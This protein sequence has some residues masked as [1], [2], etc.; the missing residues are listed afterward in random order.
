MCTVGAWGLTGCKTRLNPHAKKGVCPEGFSFILL[1][2]ALIF[3][4]AAGPNFP[5]TTETITPAFSKT[6]PSCSTAEIPSP[7]SG[8][9]HWSIRNFFSGSRACN[10]ERICFWDFLTK[11]SIRRR[12]GSVSF[13]LD[14]SFYK[15]NAR[16]WGL[17]SR[18]NSR[19][20]YGSFRSAIS[21]VSRTRLPL[22]GCTTGDCLE[23]PWLQ[24]PLSVRWMLRRFY[25]NGLFGLSIHF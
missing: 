8:R 17:P 22:S 7:P 9:V 19:H 2:S 24:Q 13:T 14:R 25:R 21:D 11:A 12:I 15:F 18:K 1:W 4:T 23:L 16:D 6:W 10:V 5:W 3:S 20:H